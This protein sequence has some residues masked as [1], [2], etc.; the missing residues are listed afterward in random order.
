MT[1]RAD[2]RQHQDLRRVEGARGE[3][4]ASPGIDLFAATA[5]ANRH[6][7]YAPTLD[8]Q[9]FD[10][11]VGANVEIILMADRLDIGAARRP[12]LSVALRHLEDAEAC[13]P[14]VVE[15]VGLGQLQ[16]GGA[17][18]EGAAGFVGPLLVGHEKRP[19]RPVI[20]AFA[21]FVGFGFPKPREHVGEAPSVAAHRGPVVVIPGI[22]ADID[23]RV[24]RRRTAQ[25]LAA[26]LMA[27]APVQPLLRYGFVQVVRPGA[28]EGHHAGRLDAHGVVAPARL[29]QTHAARPAH[30][31]PSGDCAAR[32]AAADHD[33]VVLFHA[34]ALSLWR[35]S[36][37]LRKG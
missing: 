17:L 6:P 29:D 8:D 18:H 7:G 2:P 30:G 35:C 25:P 15:I 5:L 11:G 24:D 34:P 10:Q 21:A 1:A 14:L 37:R 9:P 16:R 20:I 32:A 23:H 22:A 19:A 28:E 3:D 36:L 27:D 31:E 26:R 13:L 4:H 33:I 12:A